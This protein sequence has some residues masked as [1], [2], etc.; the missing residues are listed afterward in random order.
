MK[1][2]ELT[3]NQQTVLSLLE[4]SKEPLK[5]YTILSGTQKRVL[6]RLLRYTGH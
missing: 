2:E 3:K 1:K 4:Q 6:R 5:A